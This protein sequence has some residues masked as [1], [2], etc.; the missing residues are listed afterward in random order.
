MYK[1]TT[2]KCVYHIGSVNS[3]RRFTSIECDENYV[4]Y[5]L[6]FMKSIA[7]STA[8]AKLRY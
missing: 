8:T 3:E 4:V 2:S 5:H 7:K 1:N 6:N